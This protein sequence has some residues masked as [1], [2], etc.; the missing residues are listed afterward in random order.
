MRLLTC[1]EGGGVLLTEG[2][3]RRHVDVDEI[4]WIFGCYCHYSKVGRKEVVREG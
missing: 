2:I 4:E 3:S 1:E